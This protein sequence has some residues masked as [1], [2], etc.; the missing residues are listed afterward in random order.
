MEFNTPT[1]LAELYKTLSE[2][3]YYYRVRREGYEDAEMEELVLDKME[4]SVP[5]EEEFKE[6][7]QTLLSAQFEREELEY[8]N[9]LDATLKGLESK[10]TALNDS[11]N[12]RIREINELY[13]QSIEKV[14]SRAVKSGLINSSIVADKT[15]ALEKAKNEQ[16]ALILEKRDEDVAT[17]IA[18]T[19]ELQTKIDGADEYFKALREKELDKKILE[20][21]DE[22]EKTEREVFKYNNGI[23]EKETRYRNTIKQAEATLKLQFLEISMGEYTKDQ[24]VDMGYYQDVIDCVTSYYDKFS[25]AEAFQKITDE[26]KLAVYLDDMYAEVIYAYRSKAGL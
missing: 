19:E 8:I 1:T 14:E 7:A 13:E 26:K 9:S 20:L 3:Y 10:L 22:S 24:L 2:I 23:L 6:K 16:I 15:A 5:T 17:L 21:K 4:Y 25:A 11:V 12:T 18:Q